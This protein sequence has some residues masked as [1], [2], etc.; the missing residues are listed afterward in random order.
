MRC[1][2]DDDSKPIYDS[3]L[4]TYNISDKSIDS[5]FEDKMKKSDDNIKEIEIEIKNATK[6]LYT[7]IQNNIYNL[8]N[9]LI[10]LLIPRILLDYGSSDAFRKCILYNYPIK[11]VK[12]SDEFISHRVY[13][14][15]TIRTRIILFSID[16][17][18]VEPK[19]VAEFKQK[20]SCKKIMFNEN[21]EEFSANI[22]GYQTENDKEILREVYSEIINVIS[23]KMTYFVL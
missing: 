4:H 10:N 8:I 3:I 12:I 2:Y 1:Y 5:F 22:D 20:Y 11:C 21:E 19:I 6:N 17:G 13:D 14:N 16:D 15:S 9:E 23:D 18:S 7:K